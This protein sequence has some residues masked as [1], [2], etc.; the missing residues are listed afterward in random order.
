MLNPCK[1]AVVFDFW[2][3]HCPNAD[4]AT[5]QVRKSVIFT[6][7]SVLEPAAQSMLLLFHS[8][9]S[10]TQDTLMTQRSGKGYQRRGRAAKL[11]K[12]A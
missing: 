10:V 9:Q 6:R 1:L 4:A 3:S 5:R 12:Q 8:K 11:M 2:G 7:A